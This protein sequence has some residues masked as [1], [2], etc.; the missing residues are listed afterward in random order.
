[1]EGNICCFFII[2]RSQCT[3]QAK[4]KCCIYFMIVRWNLWFLNVI[5]SGSIMLVWNTFEVDIICHLVW[6]YLRF[7]LKS[8][9]HIFVNNLMTKSPSFLSSHVIFFG[10]ISSTYSRHNYSGSHW[11]AHHNR[12]YYSGRAIG[13][14]QRPIPDSTRHSHETDI[15]YPGRIRTCNPSKQA[16]AN[17]HL[18]PLG[19]WDLR[20]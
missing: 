10:R 19:H 17:T 4:F 3:L 15:Y 12:Y 20:T 7:L 5:T 13:P 2:I 14:S 16:T 9:L 6:F 18:R 8:V 11:V 1:M